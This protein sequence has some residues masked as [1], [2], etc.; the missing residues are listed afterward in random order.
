[1]TKWAYHGV[2]AAK[3]KR[4]RASGLITGAASDYEDA[5]SEY[6]DGAHLFFGDDPEQLRGSYG[7]TLLRFPWPS[8]AKPDQNKYGRYLAHQFVT[9]RNVAPAQLEVELADGSWGPLGN[10]HAT[11]RLKRKTHAQL[12]R[13][14]RETLLK[15]RA[16]R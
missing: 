11:R 12:D 4:I 10:D 8:D 1:V 14:I 16:L 7:D 6:D 2:R 5:Y 15:R 3:L 13:D 9:K